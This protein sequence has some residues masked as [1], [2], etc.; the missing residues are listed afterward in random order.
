MN[1]PNSIKNE[2]LSGL[3]ASVIAGEVSDDQ[4]DRFL[5]LLKE[6]QKNLEY[7]IEF[8]TT[9]ALL[10]EKYNN[11][12]VEDTG[13]FGAS[14]VQALL[15]S[16]E[17]AP[18][19]II[20]K[21]AELEVVKP[22]KKYKYSTIRTNKLFQIFDK[23]VYLAAV[24]MVIFIVYSHMSPNKI[25]VP[26]AIAGEQVG[27]EW[28]NV[29]GVISA[30]S[31]LYTGPMSLK[32]GLAEIVL[33]NGAEI[34]VEGPCDFRLEDDYQIYLEVGSLVANIEKVSDK[35]LVV[36]TNNATVVDY[37]T[38]FGV[39]VDLSGNTT[40][41]VYKG[42][43]ELR[44]GSDPFKYEKSLRLVK[45]QGGQV[46]HQGIYD[47]EPDSFG[48]IR[49]D[50]FDTNVKAVAGSAY[51]RWKAYSYQLKK[52]KD[53][54][55]YYT[56]EKGKDNLLTN[57]AEAT[58]GRFNGQLKTDAASFP[59]WIQGRWKQKTALK[60]NRQNQQ[61][62]QIQSDELLNINKEITLA[63]WIKIDM[64]DGGG[65]IISNR[66]TEGTINYQLG[67][68]IS[69]NPIEI[70][71]IQFARYGSEPTRKY[72]AQIDDNDLI[73]WHL[74]VAS[75]NNRQVSFYLDGKLVNIEDYQFIGSPII[76][77]LYIGSDRSIKK[78]FDGVIGEVAIFNSVLNDKEIEEMY[79][80]G[81]P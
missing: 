47:V 6:D 25:N 3:I 45:D 24:C 70:A 10:D 1:T 80:Q 63:A 48:F 56:F 8:S 76:A 9:W 32:K 73:G 69:N 15:E 64:K 78:D 81:R 40:T 23:L 35:R 20:E 27:A 22:T 31:T 2:E 60:F 62:I 38:E 12:N 43:V 57:V 42:S 7:Y 19:V 61:Y 75:H 41:R 16:E 18:E 58:A 71:K 28:D 51:H 50:E 4:Y 46:N 5:F 67:F 74:L 17:S 29:S 59:K 68:N 77:G 21:S 13:E 39:Y 53:L 33:N 36:R 11:A 54:V 79:S 26:I 66:L 65:H 34:I 49:K 37:G 52:R 14:I 72:S 44:Q 30:G 55:A